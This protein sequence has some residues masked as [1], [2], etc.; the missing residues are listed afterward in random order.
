MHAINKR[1]SHS[2]TDL[3]VAWYFKHISPSCSVFM[4]KNLNS[5]PYSVVNLPSGSHLFPSTQ[6]IQV[7]GL[8]KERTELICALAGSRDVT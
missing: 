7:N 5:K 2:S 6:C 3:L 4:T 1:M 8:L